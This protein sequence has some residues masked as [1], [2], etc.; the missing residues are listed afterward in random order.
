[1]LE[2][3]FVKP[4]T[5]DRIRASWFGDATERY[6]EWLAAQRFAEST[7]TRRVAL[8]CRFAEFAERH[9]A[10]SVEAAEPLIDAFPASWARSY[11]QRRPGKPGKSFAK[12][13]VVPIRQAIRL[14]LRG[15]VVRQRTRRDFP[16]ARAVPGFLEYLRAERGLKVA[17]IAHYRHYLNRFAVFLER[18]GVA[19]LSELSPALL[20]AFVVESAPQLSCSGRRDLC[21]CTRVLLR[22]CYRE[23]IID[24]DL[25]AAVEMPQSYRLATLPRSITWDEVRRTLQIIDQRTVRGRRDYAM[26]LLLVT[27]GLRGH[28]IAALTLDDLDL[29]RERLHIRDRK[30]GHSSVYPLAGV[31]AESIINYLQHGRPETTDRHVFFRTLAPYQPI[32]PAA[33]SSSAA[34]RLRAAGVAV[35]RAGSHT[36]RHTCVQR[37]VDAELPLK[38]V[39]DYVGHRSPD[40]TAIYAKVALS[41]LRSVAL[42]D[43]ER[44]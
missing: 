2:R 39:S 19:A 38:T 35:Y 20:A 16:F 11:H 9:G 40:S 43:G 28:E 33:V 7:I 41:T 17:T 29:K 10:C 25:S 5:I 30:A 37:L 1:M 21:G 13:A 8:L 23:R 36:L 27:Y 24:R 12:D 22:Y 42:G 31:V 3:Y 18:Q 44:L 26:L 6:V 15:T 32:S 4:S 34:Q 14:A